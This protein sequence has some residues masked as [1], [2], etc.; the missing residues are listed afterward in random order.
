LVAG[1]SLRQGGQYFVTIVAE[2]WAGNTAVAS[3]NGVVADASPPDGGDVRVATGAVVEV[4]GKFSVP[5]SP[6]LKLS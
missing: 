1:L 5:A 2:D 6:V 4:D 3:T